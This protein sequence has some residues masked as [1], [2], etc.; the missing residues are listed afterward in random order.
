MNT[1]EE[2]I[3]IKRDDRNRNEGHVIY[4]ASI[5]LYCQKAIATETENEMPSFV[6]ESELKQKI[7]QHIRD[8]QMTGRTDAFFLTDKIKAFPPIKKTGDK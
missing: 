2:A 4:T 8:I 7:L 6:I 3:Q 5:T 1:I